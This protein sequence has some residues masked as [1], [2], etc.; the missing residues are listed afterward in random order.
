MAAPA[1]LTQLGR[2]LGQTPAWV[3]QYIK[4]LETAG[5][6]EI[7][8]VKTRGIVVEKYY[9]SCANAYLLQQFV[10][11]SGKLPVLIFSGSHDLAFE[12]LADRLSRH[13]TLLALSVGSLDGLVNLR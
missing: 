9:R 6:V 4:T 13:I 2:V 3:R 1:T 11:P 10:L 7:A 12:W 8:E 5:L